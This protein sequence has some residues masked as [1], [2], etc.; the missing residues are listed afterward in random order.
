ME[1]GFYWIISSILYASYNSVTLISMLIPMKKYINSKKNI[2]FISLM[3]MIIIFVLALIIYSLID[4]INGDISKID[5]PVVYAVGKF[6]EMYKYLY[7][8]IIISAITTTAISSAYG[9]LNNISDTQKKYKRYNL[10]ICITSVFVAF[11]GF[12]NLVNILYP[13]FGF[14]GLV[15]L[16]FILKCK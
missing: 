1:I 4:T 7:G 10:L 6:G 13:L 3:C 5:L 15:Q 9:F 2:I 8:V 14:L 11:I 16:I 12:S